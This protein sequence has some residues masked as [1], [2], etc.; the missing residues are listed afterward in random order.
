MTSMHTNQS[1]IAALATLRTTSAALQNTQTQISSGYRIGEAKDNAA[2]WSIATTMRSDDKALS[3]VED[4]LGLGAALVDVTYTGM[5]A[6][7]DAVDRIKSDLV[8]A[9]EPGV[10]KNKINK[11]ID[12]LKDQLYTI[13]E[14][15][16]FSG[17]NWLYR[18]D[19]SDDSDKEVV[20]SFT[21]DAAGNVAVQT[22]T[23]KMS[24][25]LGTNHLIDESYHNG[26]LTNVEFARKLGTAT[27]WVLMNGRH[28][29]IHPTISL[30][31]A[32]TPEDIDEMV[33]VVDMMLS[34]MTDAAANLGA[35]N[36]RVSGQQDFV[37]SLRDSLSR[38][39]GKLVDADM[40]EESTRLK[41][42]QT[43]QQLGFQSLSI[44][45]AEPEIMLK[46][47]Q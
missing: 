17:Q 19:A 44:A 41:A 31:S 42:L 38:G 25:D 5:T 6:A 29:Q 47:F 13:V 22:V 30:S 16:S 8:A 11:D 24:S 34:Y 1:A 40:N 37:A 43:Q 33:S 39:T 3:T 7:I 35:M 20:G 46:L 9:R 23:Y 21:R 36:Q 26:I 45:N 12:Q 2:Y 28:H 14:S 18:V 32:T 4:S 10:D 15:S 27:E